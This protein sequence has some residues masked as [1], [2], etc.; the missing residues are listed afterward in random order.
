MQEIIYIPISNT[1]RGLSLEEALVTVKKCRDICPNNGFLGYVSFFCHCFFYAN[2][3]SCKSNP[4]GNWFSTPVSEEDYGQYID[5]YINFAIYRFISKKKKLLA[6]NLLQ[7]G[8]VGCFQ[9]IRV[10]D[11]AGG[12]HWQRWFIL[13]LI[14]LIQSEKQKDADRRQVI[15]KGRPWMFKFPPLPPMFLFGSVLFWYVLLVLV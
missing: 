12:H 5:I 8:Q 13:I 15:S 7:L 9:H 1:A 10:A 6:N 3:A 11:T 4:S 14:L 2:V